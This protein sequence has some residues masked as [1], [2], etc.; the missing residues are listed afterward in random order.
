MDFSFNEREQAFRKEV[1]DFME[2]ETPPRWRELDPMYL[3]ETDEIMA[4]IREFQCK[5]AKKRWLSPGYP[6]EYGGMSATQ[7][8]RV[9]LDEELLYHKAPVG[10]ETGISVDWVG[11][12]ILRFGTEE[13][14]QKYASGIARAEL[15]FCLGYSEPNAG[16]D[17]AAIQTTAIEKEDYYEVNGQKIW[18]SCAEYADYIWLAARTDPTVPKHK[19]ISLFI[20][21]TRVPG[22]T[23]SPIVNMMGD[24][25][26]NEVFFDN[27]KI[28]KESL[29]GEKNQGWYQL[30][31]ALTFERSVVG[32]ANE[33][34]RII[35]DLILYVRHTSGQSTGNCHEPIIRHKLANLEI[36]YQVGRLLCYRIAS[37]QHKGKGHLASIEASV[38]LAYQCDLARNVADTGMEILGLLGQLNR[39]DKWAPM[40]GRVMRLYLSSISTGVGGGS[41]DIQRNIIANM[42]LGLKGS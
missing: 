21:D 14:K 4:L 6:E 16:S 26:F 31:V 17:L 30:M 25:G 22:I 32:L 9:T 11:P 3:E 33:A 41:R 42:G 19:G 40:N 38:N 24:H 12:S 1:C 35:D 2:K 27:V 28:P 7:W 18:T 5:L 20:V 34:K 15:L 23:I 13:Q 29:V 39:G 8:E 37:M 36:Q 10:L